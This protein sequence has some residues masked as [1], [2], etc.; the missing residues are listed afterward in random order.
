MEIDSILANEPND[1]QI[2]ELLE[3][4]KKR[5]GLDNV[6]YA[7]SNPA[8]GRVYG[9]MTYDEGWQR[10]YNEQG[11]YHIDP[12]LVE[13]RRSI[14]PVDWER[15][16]RS[17][18]FKTVFNDARDFG[19]SDQ[20]LTIPVR[21]PLGD[22][23][24]LSVNSALPARDWQVLKTQA[25]V[26][27]QALAVH[28]HDRVMREDDLMRAMTAPNLSRREIE[29]LQWIA[30]GKSQ[31]DIGD[32]LAISHRTVEVHLRSAR[33]KLNA[34]TTAQAIGRALSRGLI[35]PE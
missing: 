1:L 7:G 23:G 25:L 27:L 2:F 31:Q 9:I 10:H 35:Y 28:I 4:I 34:L 3:E 18:S 12:T 13:A 24:A 19:I 16:E 14:A 8:S 17:E 5:Y 21:G 6:A 20:G 33:T 15:I 26:E 32:I 22:V 30:A 29:I 11:Y